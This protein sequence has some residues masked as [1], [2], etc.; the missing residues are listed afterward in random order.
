MV[1]GDQESGG[2]AVG[3]GWELGVQ[4]VLGGG[5]QGVPQAGAVVAGV[6]VLLPRL[7]GSVS[8]LAAGSGQVSGSN[9]AIS[10]APSSADPRP[11]TRTPPARSGLIDR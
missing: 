8:G 6:A 7:S 1:E 4:G 2:G 5:D 11:R 9:A 10:R 3:L